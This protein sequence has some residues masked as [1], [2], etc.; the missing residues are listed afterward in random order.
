MNPSHGRALALRGALLMEQARSEAHPS[1]TLLAEA[2]DCL[3]RAIA[4]NRFV[5]REYGSLLDEARRL[6][7]DS[8]RLPRPTAY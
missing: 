7:R 1:S 8:A 5:S 3:D 4:V 6:A 2:R